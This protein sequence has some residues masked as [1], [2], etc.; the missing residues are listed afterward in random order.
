MAVTAPTADREIERKFLARGDG[1]RANICGEPIP[2]RA[3]Y[4]SVRPEAVVRVRMEGEVAVLTLKGKA[5]DAEGR[6]RAEYNFP[7]PVAQAEAI[8]AGPMIAG[9]VVCKTRWPVRV[10][11]SDFVVDVFEHP[12]P[13]L[14]LI[15]IELPH[16]D[17][18]FERPDWLGEDVTAD[19]SYANSVLA[20]EA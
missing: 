7:I 2:M 16:R 10:G 8:L 11:D 6:E 12:R 5:I 9:G 1:W 14:V 3:G 19:F 15:E 17:A 18:D 13:G 4:L 20:A